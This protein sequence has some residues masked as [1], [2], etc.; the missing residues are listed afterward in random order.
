MMSG[1][2][3]E[4]FTTEISAQL[5]RL[6]GEIERLRIISESLIE[7]DRGDMVAGSGQ[8]VFFIVC[9]FAQCMEGRHHLFGTSNV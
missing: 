2:V 9:L 1:M 7:L 5:Q 6:V 4:Q 3:A 8:N